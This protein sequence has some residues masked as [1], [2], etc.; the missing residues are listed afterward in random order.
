[1]A[2][3]EE[4]Q[5][6][7]APGN[8]GEDHLPSASIWPAG[9]AFGIALLLIGLVVA[10]PVAA[11]GGVFAVLFGLLWVRDVTSGYRGEAVPPR[12]AAAAAPVGA[13]IEEEEEEW[14][15]ERYPRSVFLERTTLGL[16]ALIGGVVTA[17]VVGFAIAPAFVG[18]DDKD[19]DVGPFGNFPEGTYVVATFTSN[20]AEGQ[21]SRQTVFVRN[22]GFVGGVPSFT[23]LSN[24]CAHLGC[25][26]QP[27]GP[28]D[29]KNPQTVETD[30]GEVTLIPSQP[31][32]FGCPCHGGQYDNEGN[33]TAGPPVRALDRYQYKIVG[34]NL[35]LG[36]RYSVGAVVGEGASAKIRAYTRLDPGQHVDGPDAWMYPVSPRGT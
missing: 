36:D 21:V 18:Q 13:A 14:E 4:G 19:V 33:R 6:A 20:E 11:I 1:V 26:T 8:G 17:P 27:N 25:P 10:W 30:S 23:I 16:G 12:P 22:N 15:P 5:G 7:P 29:T 28:T 9:F 2:A 24:R 32:G 34:G 35:V 3:E 31:A